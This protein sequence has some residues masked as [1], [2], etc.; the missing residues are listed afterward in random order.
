MNIHHFTIYSFAGIINS[1]NYSAN[2]RI[3]KIEDN[4]VTFQWKDYKDQNKTKIMTLDALEF[5]RRF[6]LHELP[7][8]F[9]KIRHYDFLSNRNKRVHIPVCKKC[10]EL[11]YKVQHPQIKILSAEELILKITGRDIH[12]CPSCKKGRM[13][14]KQLLRSDLFA[15]T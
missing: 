8:K 14:R 9:V 6:L 2:E 3:V 1:K 12:I 4:Q 15:P 13:Y 11:L 5:I 10:I 7:P